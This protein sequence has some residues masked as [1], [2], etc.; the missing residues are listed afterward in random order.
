[1]GRSVLTRA[2]TVLV[3]F[4]LAAGAVW[5]QGKVDCG[6]AHR[7]FL[8]KLDRGGFGNVSPE[9]RAVLMRKAQRVRDACQTG[10]IEDTKALFDRLDGT[11]Y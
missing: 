2:A 7:S 5:A 9:Q 11:K 4:A 8:D 1:M 10:D 3:A 6:K